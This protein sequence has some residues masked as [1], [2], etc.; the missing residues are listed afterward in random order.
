[1]FHEISMKSGILKNK[2][3]N[4]TFFPT[5]YVVPYV[6]PAR[7]ARLLSASGTTTSTTA[8]TTT[9]YTGQSVLASTFVKNWRIL[10]E[11][12]F[13]AHMALLAAT[14]AFRLGRRC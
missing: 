8:T 2:P 4:F 12:S 13:T 10:W 11:Q 6:S 5:K 1:M 7:S 9:I 14:T 3:Q